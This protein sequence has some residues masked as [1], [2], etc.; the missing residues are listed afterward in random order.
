MKKTKLRV[1]KTCNIEFIPTNLNKIYCTHKCFLSN[2]IKTKNPRKFGYETLE[3]EIWKDVVGVYGYKISNLGRVLSVGREIY[4]PTGNFKTQDKLMTIQTNIYGYRTVMLSPGHGTITFFIHKLIALAFIPNPHNKPEINHIN[5]IK[6]DNSIINLEWCTHKE[7]MKHARDT[8]LIKKST[9][10]TN[11]D[12]ELINKYYF[13]YKI[14]RIISEKTG[15]PEKAITRYLH[16]NCYLHLD[17]KTPHVT[18][19][20]LCKR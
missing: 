20:R 18:K 13:E 8:G 5:G 14:H 1:C 10:I 17:V 3:G 6:S 12:A 7:N 4:R 9:T 19:R 15:I 16:G 2:R 11:E